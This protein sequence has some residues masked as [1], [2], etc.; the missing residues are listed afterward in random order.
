MTRVAWAS[1]F[2]VAMAFLESAVV[3]YLRKIY[4]PNGFQFPLVALDVPIA[5]TEIFREAATV[6]ML[7]AI[8]ILTGRSRYEK[9]AF[10]LLCF[11]IW[12]IFYYVFLWLLLGWPESLLTWDILFLIPVMWIGPVVAPVILS[13]TMI[14]LATVILKYE[15]EKIHTLEW[16][17]LVVGSVVVMVS[18]TMDY[19][20]VVVHEGGWSSLF[21]TD[22]VSTS[23]RERYI[24]R[25][26]PW[27]FFWIGEGVVVVSVARILRRRWTKT[28]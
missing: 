11:A 14:G 22:A 19:T 18:F 5:V 10:F 25:T 6:V 17:L 1:I 7:V 28:G 16:A 21:S 20:T 15:I 2:A 27:W 26:F 8:G 13:L 24:P 9:F 4:Y 23:I 12:D 3:V